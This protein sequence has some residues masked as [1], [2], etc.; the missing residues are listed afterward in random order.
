MSY[1]D[2][3][4]A[5]DFISY[6]NKIILHYIDK[7]NI[8]IPTLTFVVSHLYVKICKS[9]DMDIN[10]IIESIY[11]QCKM[12]EEFDKIGAPHDLA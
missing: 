8:D 4:D 6:L 10:S 7:H 5:K 2:F 12:F 3:Q 9:S 11:L 1:D